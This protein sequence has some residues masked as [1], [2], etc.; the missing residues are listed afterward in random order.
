MVV[1]G[2]RCGPPEAGLHVSVNGELIP[3]VDFDRLTVTATSLEGKRPESTTLELKGAELQWPMTFNFLSGARTGVGSSVEVVARAW[4]GTGAVSI[5]VGHA[6]LAPGTGAALELFLTRDI[7]FDEGDPE[8]AGEDPALDDAGT[9][10]YGGVDGGV[11]GGGAMDASVPDAGAI[12]G[13]PVDAGTHDAGP[14]DAGMFDAGSPDAGPQT[15]TFYRGINFN[16]GVVT[17]NG[18][19]WQSYAAAVNGGL[20]TNANGFVNSKHTP[21][22]Q[23]DADTYA[24]LNTCIWF[25][26]ADL[27]VDV[28]VPNDTYDVY[29]WVMENYKSNVRAFDVRMEGAIVATGLATMPYPEWR[30]FGPYPATVQDGVLDLDFLYKFGDPHIMGLELYR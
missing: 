25:N 7:P 14:T 3:G 19:V 24:V 20:T 27:Y 26:N 15:P 23:V 21:T 29:L 17:I 6:E 13:G 12:D 9:E 1:A 30:R 5:A 18:N 8:D 16:G 28:P 2:V 22:P 11:D 10:T 4:L